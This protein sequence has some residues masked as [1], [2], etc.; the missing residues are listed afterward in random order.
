[1]ENYQQKTTINGVVINIHGDSHKVNKRVRREASFRVPPPP[2]FNGAPGRANSPTLSS[3]SG[4]PYPM[5]QGSNP[6]PPMNSV[7]SARARAMQVRNGIFVAKLFFMSG[8]WLVWIEFWS[9]LRHFL[10]GQK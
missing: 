8:F 9:I 6:G 2:T 7:E 1:M 10:L 3:A 5:N 4:S